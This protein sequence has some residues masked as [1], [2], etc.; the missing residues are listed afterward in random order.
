MFYLPLQFA[1][2]F[3]QSFGYEISQLVTV[4][5]EEFQI[6]P[7]FTAGALNDQFSI[8]DPNQIYA[9]E[10]PTF[11]VLVWILFG[12]RL[13]SVQFAIVIITVPARRDE[14]TTTALTDDGTKRRRSDE[15]M[16]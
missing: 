4:L 6:P 2:F 5:F 15:G 10:S 11:N 13:V 14:I 9:I 16:M 7:G 12:F 3:F 8:A 1:N